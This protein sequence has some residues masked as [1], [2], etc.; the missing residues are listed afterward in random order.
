MAVFV[1]DGEYGYQDIAALNARHVE[2]VGSEVFG[3][4][5][6]SLW[7]C[8][9]EDP[10]GGAVKCTFLSVANELSRRENEKV[11][12]GLP[13]REVRDWMAEVVRLASSIHSERNQ[14]KC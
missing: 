9:A 5:T 14:R 8:A 10:E 2:E 11:V 4:V 3:L 12:N 6:T 7:R 13:L 1:G